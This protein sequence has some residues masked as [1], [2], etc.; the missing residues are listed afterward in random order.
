VPETRGWT[1]CLEALGGGVLVSDPRL[2]GLEALQPNNLLFIDG[3]P[4]RQLRRLVVPF[5]A[6]HRLEDLGRRLEPTCVEALEQAFA[7]PDSDL[8]T[9][10]VEPLVLEAILAAMGVPPARWERLSALARDML[11]LLEPELPPAARRRT[12]NAAMR[13]TMLFE[14]DRLQGEAV[15]LHG[16]L[17]AAAAEGAIPAKLARSTPVVVLHGGYE[18]PLNQLGCLV[19]WAVENPARFKQGA[20]SSPALLFEEILRVYSPVRAVARWA[21]DDEPGGTRWRKG[22][23]VWVSLESANRDPD[24]FDDAGRVDPSGRRRHLGFGHGLHACLGTALARLEGRALI[25]TLA[26]FPDTALREFSVEWG[27]GIVA[28]GPTRIARR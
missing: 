13:A 10:V 5:F 21:A 14:R 18:N 3:E 17:E 24:R 22:D 26:G 28:R 12:A 20:A 6:S 27:E 11:G 2:A 16:S 15:G 4:H 7:S 19:A 9:D 25:G 8:L 23:L 1:E